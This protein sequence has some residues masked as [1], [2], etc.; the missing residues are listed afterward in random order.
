MTL[1]EKLPAVAEAASE[2]PQALEGLTGPAAGGS[3][4]SPHASAKSGDRPTIKSEPEEA[5]SPSGQQD[6]RE[7]GNMDMGPSSASNPHPQPGMQYFQAIPVIPA[8]DFCV[9]SFPLR[10]RPDLHMPRTP[11]PVLFPPHTLR[12]CP[13]RH[14]DF[15]D[16]GHTSRKMCQSALN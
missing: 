6:A 14:V 11:L 8:Q 4:T 7:L 1:Q 15:H 3:S 5:N 13:C 10:A 2:S 12:L 16:A 9:A